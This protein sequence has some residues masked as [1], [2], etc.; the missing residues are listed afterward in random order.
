MMETNLV[1]LRPNLL[2]RC[3]SMQTH[4]ITR[5]QHEEL[6]MWQGSSQ[7]SL[8]IYLDRLQTTR[9]YNTTSRCRIK[10]TRAEQTVL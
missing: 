3:R 5:H 9:L 6:D 10:I 8:A 4:T 1:H 7:R 2:F